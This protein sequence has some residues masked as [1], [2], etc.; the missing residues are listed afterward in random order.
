MTLMDDLNYLDKLI[1]MRVGNLEERAEGFHCVQRLKM[2]VMVIGNA[3][4]SDT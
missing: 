1:S 4:G 3:V 2:F